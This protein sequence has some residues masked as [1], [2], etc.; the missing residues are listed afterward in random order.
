[1]LLAGRPRVHAARAA[2]RAVLGLGAAGGLGSPGCSHRAC[3][4]AG[5]CTQT[6]TCDGTGL[7]VPNIVPPVCKPN[8][9]E[10][11]GRI[12]GVAPGERPRGAPTRHVFLPHGS[13]CEFER[14]RMCFLGCSL[15]T[16]CPS[17]LPFVCAPDGCGGAVSC[18][19]CSAGLVCSTD[20]K[21]CREE[22]TI[23]TPVNVC[24]KPC[25]PQVRQGRLCVA[26][27]RRTRAPRVHGPDLP[28]LAP[29]A[30][31]ACMHPCAR[32]AQP[33]GCGG[34]LACPNTCPS[35]G[36]CSASNEC[37]PPPPEP[38]KQVTQ[39]C[40]NTS[41]CCGC[42]GAPPARVRARALSTLQTARRPPDTARARAPR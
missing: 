6:E 4:R 40:T 1:M 33:D 17:P 2:T 12:C 27:G 20:G 7:C 35:G 15:H 11:E 9:T 38:C 22:P 5:T 21:V 18:G 41:Q 16:L 32:R 10:C 14:A 39:S 25:G 28:A 37:L 29:P 34:V 36:L 23:C 31:H 42:G 30:S 24:L 19:E 26:C 8:A 3:A 13:A